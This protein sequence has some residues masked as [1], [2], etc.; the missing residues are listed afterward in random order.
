MILGG[1]RRSYIRDRANVPHRDGQPLLQPT[2]A[3]INFLILTT[4][5]EILTFEKSFKVL[6]ILKMLKALK[7]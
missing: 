6:K 4:L 2:E 1:I 7:G 3:I 5:Q